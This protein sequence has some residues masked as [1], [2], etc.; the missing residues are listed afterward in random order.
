MAAS[1][2]EPP[3]YEAS[4]RGASSL[5]DASAARASRERASRERSG[6]QPAVERFLTASHWRL[7]ALAARLMPLPWVVFA[8]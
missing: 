8:S 3:L 7:P 1:K 5:P 2:A 6:P 4:S